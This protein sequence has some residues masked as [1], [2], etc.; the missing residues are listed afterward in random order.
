MLC[1]CSS[2]SEDRWEKDRKGEREETAER[3]SGAKIKI[4]KKET[5]NKSGMEER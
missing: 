3:E 5:D 1:D 4:K 2:L